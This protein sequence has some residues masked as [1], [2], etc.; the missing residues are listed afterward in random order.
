MRPI[1]EPM[2]NVMTSDIQYF[3]SHPCTGQ[4]M[5]KVEAKVVQSIPEMS[6]ERH[7]GVMG[8]SFHIIVDSTGKVASTNR[9]TKSVSNGFESLD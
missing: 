9:Q 5:S 7:L 2:E 4:N 6:A 3:Q 1:N 8:S